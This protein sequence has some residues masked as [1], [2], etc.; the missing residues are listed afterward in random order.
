[1]RLRQSFF[2]FSTKPKQPDLLVAWLSGAAARRAETLTPAEVLAACWRR[3]RASVA[4]V[5]GVVVDGQVLAEPVE[6]IRSTWFA[7]EFTRGSYSYRSLQSNEQVP[8]EKESIATNKIGN[9]IHQ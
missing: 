1:M 2:F 4:G 6:L 8:N 7:D 9:C 3:L 5:V